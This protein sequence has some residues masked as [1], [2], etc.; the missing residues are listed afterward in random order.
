MNLVSEV[1]SKQKERIVF[2]YAAI[3]VAFFA[4]T[5]L[6]SSPFIA[7]RAYRAVRVSTGRV[8][9][10]SSQAYRELIDASSAL[11]KWDISGALKN[12]E[13][14]HEHFAAIEAEAKRYVPLFQIALAF[15][16]KGQSYYHLA[17]TGLYSTKAATILG[18]S[19]KTRDHTALSRLAA[20]QALIESARE[21]INQAEEES[22]RIVLAYFTPEERARVEELQR[23]LA[24]TASELDPM[25]ERLKVARQILGENG[26]RRYLLLF[27]NS[28]ELRP[29]GGFIGSLAIADIKDGGLNT[30]FVPHGGTYDLRYGLRERIRSPRPFS[31]LN[32][33]WQMQDCN[34]FPDF[35]A[36]AKKCAWFAEGSAGS[37]FDGV[38][39]ITDEFVIDL[40]KI[41]GP[42]P[43][44]EYGTVITAD[45]FIPFT[46]TLVESEEARLSGAPK[47]IIADFFPIMADRIF[48]SVSE[49]KEEFSLASALLAALKQK[50]LMLFMEDDALQAH[51]EK[52][53]W[54]GAI[55]DAET[56]DYLHVNTAVVNGGKSEFAVRQEARY[57][58]LE[59][60][61]GALIASLRVTRGHTVNYNDNPDFAALVNRDNL[62]YIRVYAP[63]GS[64]LIGVEGDIF[65]PTPFF[66]SQGDDFSD[67]EFLLATEGSPLIDE[68]TKT[69]ITEEFGKTSFGN[70]LIIAPGEEKTI[71]FIYKLPFAKKDLKE[72]GYSLFAQKQGG[73]ASRLSVSEFGKTL[74]EGELEE[75]AVIR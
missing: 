13:K 44:P 26:T 24:F 70:Y 41:F 30:F 9:G 28:G 7:L 43:L 49:P 11:H 74:Y 59:D 22:K 51:L 35:R 72:R 36:S 38:V 56:I 54:A 17:K 75:D 47:Q 60:A 15:S 68:R 31:I 1:A 21:P 66:Q 27:Q 42:I 10:E 71:T 69:R 52:E 20:F 19:E 58:V 61:S 29:T 39:A 65:D 37:S 12:V 50:N 40:L 63:R 34:W 16:K 14:A 64:E 45:N 32:P 5:L 55:E 33:E 67:D 57:D 25:L 53:N 18:S 48:G 23:A 8:A 6:A 73:M 46:Q 3:I 62:A 2:R 4:I